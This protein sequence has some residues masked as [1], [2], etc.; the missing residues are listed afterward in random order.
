MKAFRYLD[1]ARKA[2]GLPS[3]RQLSIRL[4]WSHN[5]VSNYRTGTSGFDTKASIQIAVL[6]GIDPLAVIADMET[7]RAKDR[8]VKSYW[9][10]VKKAAAA[11][12]LGL[13]VA[14]LA[15]Q[16]M[17]GTVCILCKIRT[18]SRK[19]PLRAIAEIAR[20]EYRVTDPRQL[21]SDDQA[22]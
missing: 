9:R 21:V 3:D 16:E 10:G 8:I 20:S 19:P 7:E 22:A 12:A 2:A 13:G 17:A 5:R 11:G 14:L 18:Q 15:A 6:I 1:A 4:G